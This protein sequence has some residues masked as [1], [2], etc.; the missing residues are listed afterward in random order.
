MIVWTYINLYNYLMYRYR[1]SASGVIY[2]GSC[3]WLIVAIVQRKR[4]DTQSKDIIV[5]T[6]ILHRGYIV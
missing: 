5:G 2:N 6:V 1:V 3:T 4:K